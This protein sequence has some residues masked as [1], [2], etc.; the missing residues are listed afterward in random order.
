MGEGWGGEEVG[1]DG[2][3]R[4]GGGRRWAEGGEV[5]GGQGRGMRLIKCA[6]FLYIHTYIHTLYMYTVYYYDHHWV[7]V[8]N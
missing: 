5:R 2:E 7:T 8:Y 6:I 3:R 1:E 4:W